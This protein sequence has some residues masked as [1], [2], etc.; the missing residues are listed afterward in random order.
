[1][2]GTAVSS[3][4]WRR[5]RLGQSLSGARW[6]CNPMRKGPPSFLFPHP[7][8]EVGY[9][10]AADQ[11]FLVDGR[12]KGQDKTVAKILFYL[13]DA[14]RGYI[15][16][17]ANPEKEFWIDHFLQLVHRIIDNEFSVISGLEEIKPAIAEK[18]SDLFYADADQFLTMFHQETLPVVLRLQLT[19]KLF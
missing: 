15:K 7:L 12:P 9:F 10:L 17:P 4:Y 6:I 5:Q 1:M 13:I 16:S 19:P 14:A 18:I 8:F 11:R 3:G 2:T